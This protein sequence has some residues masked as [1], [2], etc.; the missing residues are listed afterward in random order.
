[1]S[2]LTK[3]PLVLHEPRYPLSFGSTLPQVL[4]ILSIESTNGED[5]GRIGWEVYEAG[6]GRVHV[7]SPEFSHLATFTAGMVGNAIQV[8]PGSWETT[9]GDQLASPPAP[10]GLSP[11]QLS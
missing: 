2:W 11:A 6:P 1:M 4:R 7:T 8:C 5:R 9:F 3:P 10:F